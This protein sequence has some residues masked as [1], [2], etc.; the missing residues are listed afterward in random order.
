MGRTPCDSCCCELTALGSFASTWSPASSVTMFRSNDSFY[1]WLKMTGFI[2]LPKVTP[3]IR[4]LSSLILFFINFDLPAGQLSEL[5]FACRCID[6]RGKSWK[7]GLDRNSQRP[8]LN[9]DSAAD[10]KILLGH[11]PRVVGGEE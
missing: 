1:W 9:P 4:T 2:G 5:C 8:E 6:L 7:W 3:M 10:Y 11:P